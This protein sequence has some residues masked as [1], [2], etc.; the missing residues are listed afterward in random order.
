M[1]RW[2][3]LL[4]QTPTNGSYVVAGQG[5]DTRTS[6]SQFR[7]VKHPAHTSA[8]LPVIRSGAHSV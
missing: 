8:E 3:R 1:A 2:H 5:L 4:V 6:K 7:R